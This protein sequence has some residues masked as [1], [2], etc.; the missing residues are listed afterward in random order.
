MGLVGRGEI[1]TLADRAGRKLL[2]KCALRYAE[3]EELSLSK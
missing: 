2:P 3:R 1:K